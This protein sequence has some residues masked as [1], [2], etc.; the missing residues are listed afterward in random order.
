MVD[1]TP[2]KAM[3][4]TNKGVTYAG[5]RLR[6]FLWRLAAGLILIGTLA[7]GTLGVLFLT[8]IRRRVSFDTL[9]AIYWI[10]PG[11][12]RT[13]SLLRILG[14]LNLTVA[15]TVLV[16]TLFLGLVLAYG[17]WNER[18]WAAWLETVLTLYPGVFLVSNWWR[19]FAAE[20]VRGL[21]DYFMVGNGPAL[22]WVLVIIALLWTDQLVRLLPKWKGNAFELPKPAGADH[23]AK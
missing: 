6:Q 11:L 5:M 1:V 14:R 15:W 19:Y 3:G 2:I 23:A 16:L 20:G 13:S 9:Q 17:L 21:H 22:L 12:D 8:G 7:E 18:F 4:R 10:P